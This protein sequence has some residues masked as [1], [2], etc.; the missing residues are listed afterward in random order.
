MP[1]R[2]TLLRMT[3][4][5]V[6]A[7]TLAAC[8]VAPD[9]GP[10]PDA[11]A[12]PPA[13]DYEATL[14]RIVQAVVTPGGLVDYVRL[15][16]EFQAE[17]DSVL[18]AVEQFDPA[19]LSSDAEKLAFFMNAYNV[20]MLK[21]ILDAPGLNNIETEGRFDDFFST[22]F[23]VAGFNMTLNQLENG[24]LRLKDSVDGQFLPPGLV[25]VRPSEL[26]PRIHMGLNCAAVSCPKLRQE[27]FRVAIVSSQLDAALS[28]FADSPKLASVN[29]A[30]V[31]ISSLVNWFGEDFDSTGVPVG[32]YFLAVMSPSR[33]GFGTIE[34]IF[35]GRDAQGIRDLVDSEP[36]FQFAYDWT[37]NRAN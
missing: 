5:L 12:V 35:K 34:S 19:R 32:D 2:K 18:A 22:P 33:P 27:A 8:T 29:G 37:V 23:R 36:T 1:P 14:T 13:A 30:E 20:R 11:P 24:I 21:N 4:P 25:A 16:A 9:A 28:D 17:F 31:T 26:D 3:L 7:L 6:L 10:P 15:S